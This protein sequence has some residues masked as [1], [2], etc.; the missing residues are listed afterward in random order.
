MEVKVIGFLK[1]KGGRWRDYSSYLPNKNK[2]RCWCDN[3]RDFRGRGVWG[4]VLPMYL[5]KTGQSAVT[6]D[7]SKTLVIYINIT[8][9]S[10]C[11]FVCLSVL[12]LLLGKLT[13]IDEWYTIGSGIFR[14][15]KLSIFQFE[16]FTIPGTIRQKLQNLQIPAVRANNQITWF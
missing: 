12:K 10:F 7:G 3:Q 16:H 11:V 15:P 9:M 8:R 2:L 6:I 1:W 14:A 4:F 5:S 13:S